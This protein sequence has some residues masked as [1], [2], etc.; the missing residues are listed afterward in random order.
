MKANRKKVIAICAAAALMVSAM[1]TGAVSAAEIPAAVQAANQQASVLN[2]ADVGQLV[3]NNNPQIRNN[4]LTRRNLEANGNDQL[5]QG[6][7][8]LQDMI[9]QIKSV[10]TDATNALVWAKTNEAKVKAM[11]PDDAEAIAQATALAQIAMGNQLSISSMVKNLEAQLE[12]MKISKDQRTLVNIQLDQVDDQLVNAAQNL[13]GVCKQLEISLEQMNASRPLLVTA[14]NLA[15]VQARIGMGTQL[16]VTEAQISLTE[17][18]QNAASLNN[19]LQSLKRQLNNLLGRAYDTPFELGALPQPDLAYY[20]AGTLAER[21]KTA[22]GN[23]YTIRYKLEE[24]SQ[25]DNDDE[26]KSIERTKQI[27]R[28]EISSEQASLQASMAAQDASIQAAQSADQL[29]RQKVQ[30]AQ[31]KYEQAQLKYRLG[32]ASRV[33]MESAQADAVSAQAAQK[34]TQLELFNQIEAYRWMVNGLP[35]SGGTGAA[36]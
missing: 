34:N 14:K 12:Q 8:D 5:K 1:G 18:D 29:Q 31:T 19:Q 15:E 2:Y 3:R 21:T 28:N 30:V 27:K 16:A 6:R 9:D 13:F 10:E 26:Y 35:A 17:F 22:L 23:N 7:E 24:L 20:Y 25:I 36:Q 32:M 4:A 33:E 11:H